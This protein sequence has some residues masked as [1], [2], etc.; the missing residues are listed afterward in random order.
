M[1]IKLVNK[2]DGN[3]EYIIKQKKTKHGYDKFVLKTSK[4][5]IWFD[6]AKN[7][8]E[9][10]MIDNGNDYVIKFPNMD[11]IVLD[12]EQLNALYLI[13]DNYIKETDNFSPSY[14]RLVK[15]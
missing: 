12:T 15:K 14:E 10:E 11:N 4:S 1:K 8:K 6:S 9:I 5:D 3:I 2:E 13:I 7:T